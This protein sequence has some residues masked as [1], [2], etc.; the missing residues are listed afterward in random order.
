M[1]TIHLQKPFLL[2]GAVSASLATFAV[3]S[4]AQARAG[5]ESPLSHAVAEALRSPFHGDHLPH[6]LR[7]SRLLLSAT[8]HPSGV[9]GHA[10]RMHRK[11]RH[12][13]PRTTRGRSAKCS[14]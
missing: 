14:C 2:C 12:P 9:S 11:Q 8:V 4:S 1:T 6:G 10:G 3:E 5:L 13:L 7:D